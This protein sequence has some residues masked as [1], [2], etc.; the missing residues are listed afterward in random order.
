MGAV[1]DMMRLYQRLVSRRWKLQWL[2]KSS[3]LA[4]MANL[5]VL[6]LPSSG[7]CLMSSVSTVLSPDA[8]QMSSTA[9][10]IASNLA[11]IFTYADRFS[12][13]AVA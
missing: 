13:N 10:A 12:S 11:A 3:A 7:I 6:E 1:S 4:A 9:H 5:S 2:T 8:E